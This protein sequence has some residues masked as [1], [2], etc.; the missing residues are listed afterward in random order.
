MQNF[1]TQPFFT[2]EAYTGKKGEY[3][4]IAGTLEGC[5]RILAG[6]LDD[7]SEDALYLIGALEPFHRPEPST[8]PRLGELLVAKK[9]ITPEQLEKALRRQRETG[10]PLGSTLVK[11]EFLSEKKLLRALS[12]QLDRSPTEV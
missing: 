8:H 7:R 9:L 5:E 4:P 6:D 12:E 11:L 3:V 1:L 2:A 10:E